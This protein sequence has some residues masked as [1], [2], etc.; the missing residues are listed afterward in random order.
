MA[1]RKQLTNALRTGYYAKNRKSYGREQTERFNAP[2]IGR[3]YKYRGDRQA[4]RRR[5]EWRAQKN[6]RYAKSHDLPYVSRRKTKNLLTANRIS[7]LQAGLNSMGLGNVKVT[8]NNVGHYGH[9][10][11]LAQQYDE[12]AGSGLVREMIRLE[13]LSQGEVEFNTISDIYNAFKGKQW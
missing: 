13:Q 2:S 6:I 8:R 10:W 5:N 4:Y 7:N 11:E 9:L 12:R 3:S 1:S